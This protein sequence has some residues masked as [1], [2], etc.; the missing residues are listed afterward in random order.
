MLPKKIKLDDADVKALKKLENDKLSHQQFIDNIIESGKRKFAQFREEHERCWAQIAKK[1]GID[2]Q[3]VFYE[4]DGKTGTIT[5]KQMM[6]K[7]D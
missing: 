1:H 6:L 3:T 4:F 2:V 5:P 7:E